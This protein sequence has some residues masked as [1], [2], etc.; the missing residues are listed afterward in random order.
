ML[1][2]INRPFADLFIAPEL[3]FNLFSLAL[4]LSILF[5]HLFVSMGVERVNF[6]GVG[7]C[8]L[9]FTCSTP[10]QFSEE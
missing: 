5:A 2:S 8:S 3:L 6:K 10:Q 4:L 9:P 7:E 1:V